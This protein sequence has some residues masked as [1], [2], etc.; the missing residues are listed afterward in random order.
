MVI[1]S[2]LQLNGSLTPRQGYEPEVRHVI[3]LFSALICFIRL[4]FDEVDVYE[5]IDSLMEER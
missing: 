4:V 3:L 5:M 2:S 1:C